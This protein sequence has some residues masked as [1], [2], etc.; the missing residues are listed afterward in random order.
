MKMA[1]C[2]AILKIG[3]AKA[4]ERTPSPIKTA[5]TPAE[6]RKVRRS[7]MFLPKLSAPFGAE[8][9]LAQAL[10]NE[11][12]ERLP[13]LRGRCIPSVHSVSLVNGFARFP[14]IGHSHPPALLPYL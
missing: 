8:I 12:M 5:L 4:D 13:R 3:A 9:G 7:N 10:S 1:D 6:T 11:T 14:I 2:L